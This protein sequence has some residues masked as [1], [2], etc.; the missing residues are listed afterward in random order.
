[1]FMTSASRRTVVLCLEAFDDNVALIIDSGD[2]NLEKVSTIMLFASPVT[3][4]ALDRRRS[5]SGCH[6]V[7]PDD[8][9]RW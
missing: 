9:A 7:S 6:S 3:D 4:G 5:S 1:M 8:A 2:D